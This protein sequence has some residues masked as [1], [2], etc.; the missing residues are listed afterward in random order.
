ME[1]ISDRIFSKLCAKSFASEW[2]RPVFA[3][4][5]STIELN[6]DSESVKAYP[7]ARNQNG[8]C[9]KAILHILVAHDLTSGYAARPSY[10]A[11]FGDKISTEA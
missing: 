11:F 10:G 4:D 9:H 5:G 8:I 1:K 3:I 7:P 6:S 2:N